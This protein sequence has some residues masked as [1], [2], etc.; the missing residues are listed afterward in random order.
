MVC[1]RRRFLGMGRV[2][3]KAS[4]MVAEKLGDC[5]KKL[6]PSAF[7]SII[8]SFDGPVLPLWYFYL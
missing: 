7:V 5:E 8:I 1:G 4:G 2:L 3:V 6:L